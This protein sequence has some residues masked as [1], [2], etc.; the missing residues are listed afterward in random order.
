MRRIFLALAL[1]VAGGL[2][3]LRASPPAAPNELCPVTPEEWA[4]PTISATYEGVEVFFCCKRCRKQFLEDPGKYLQNLPRFQERAPHEDSSEPPQA[5]DHAHDHGPSGGP[6]PPPSTALQFAGKLHPLAVHFPIA[7][8]L[9]TFAFE[10]GYLI[11]RRAPWQET[12]HLLAPLAAASAVVAA[13]LGWAAGLHAGYPGALAATLTWHRRLG[14]ATAIA[15]AAMGLLSLAARRSEEG[16]FA[17]A[18]RVLLVISAA[19][20]SATGHLGGTLIYG[21]GYLPW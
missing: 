12:A 1:L 3:G 13:L 4:E 15:A 2:P 16:R 11:T 18:Y 8:V 21:P 19:L 9:V 7:L 6:S 20:V 17:L 10:L 5:H 14:I